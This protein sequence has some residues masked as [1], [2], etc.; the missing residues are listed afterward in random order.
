LLAF[1]TQ[2]LELR[3]VRLDAEEGPEFL[4][5]DSTGLDLDRVESRQPNAAAPVIRLDNCAGALVR[6][7][8]AWPG[9]NTFLSVQPGSLKGITLE[10]NHLGEAKTPIEETNGDFWKGIPSPDR[11]PSRR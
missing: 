3:N 9:T 8:R 5:R 6:G 1:N 4:I 11:L 10:G 7:S 2:G